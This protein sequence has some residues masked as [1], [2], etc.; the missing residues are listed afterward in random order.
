MLGENKAKIVNINPGMKKP[1]NRGI[2]RANDSG[3][4]GGGN[5]D[6]FVKKHELKSTE[7]HLSHQAKINHSQTESNFKLIDE[8]FNHVDEKFNRVF[9][10]LET[11]DT[12]INWV[13]G[14][15]AAV[16]GAL[17]LKVIFRIG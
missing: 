12:K 10:R 6:E 3:N 15:F 8:K 14:I 13:L 9:D 1:V 17:I 5:M 2:I 16:V 4:G 11:L 7:E